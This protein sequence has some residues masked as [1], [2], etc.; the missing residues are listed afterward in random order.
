M[1]VRLLLVIALATFVFCDPR[2]RPKI[3]NAV[4]TSSENLEPSKA[5][6]VIQPVIQPAAIAYQVHFPY[7]SGAYSPYVHGLHPEII[8]YPV[9]GNQGIAERRVEENVYPA[10]VEGL[11]SVPSAD[12]TV[13]QPVLYP[14]NVKEDNLPQQSITNNVGYSTQPNTILSQQ[15]L[16]TPVLKMEPNVV[17]VE[18]ESN[19]GYLLPSPENNRL[20]NQKLL[21]QIAQPGI[22][23][24][25]PGLTHNPGATLSRI[26]NNN[27][28]V[29]N[30][31]GASPVLQPTGTGFPYQ[32][33]NP[34][35]ASATGEAMPQTGDILNNNFRGK[36]P[37][38][39][40]VP[41]PPLPTARKPVGVPPA[42]NV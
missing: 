1:Y 36:Y 27:Q 40:D 35:S 2:R 42:P 22:S 3:Y 9:A 29:Q 34:S 23:Q 10:G 8:S 17:Q 14:K 13:A 38:I 26:E 6:P 18:T 39:P 25:S 12:I 7:V 5:Y 32:N 41:P 4:I 19:N 28:V 31:F 21:S 16:P 33:S 20:L 11:N 15:N 24:N 37:G 30:S